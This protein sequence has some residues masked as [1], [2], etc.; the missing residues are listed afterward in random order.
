MIMRALPLLLVIM[1]ARQAISLNLNEG[2][3]VSQDA[4]CCQSCLSSSTLKICSDWSTIYAVKKVQWFLSD[5]GVYSEI[6]NVKDQTYPAKNN[7]YSS[8]CRQCPPGWYRTQD[9]LCF[10][11]QCSSSTSCPGGQYV[12]TSCTPTTNFG[13]SLCGT[14]GV[15]Q[16]TQT[17]CGGTS[18]IVCQSCPSGK[19]RDSY[20]VNTQTAC[21]DCAVCKTSLRQYRQGCTASSNEK[22]PVCPEGN[23]VKVGPPDSCQLCS[24]GTYARASDNTCVT[25]KTCARTEKQ[26]SACLSTGDRTCAACGDNRYTLAVNADTC[27]GCIQSYYLTGAGSCALCADSSCGNG[28]YRTCSFTEAGGG[29]R[30]CGA[31][32][33]QTENPKCDA[34]K[35]VSTRCNGMG[36]DAVTCSPCGPGLE[37]PI[38]TALVG[39]IQACVAC[40]LGFFKDATGV[41]NC[42]ACTNKPANNTQYVSWGTT[43]PSAN[44]C[45]W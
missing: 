18:N 27:A 36:T 19:Y 7:G 6:P 43:S 10:C 26:T 40:G 42:G 20:I 44:A 22:C 31:C 28:N 29:T 25:C 33:G 2:F 34:G 14:C 5:N 11:R 37:R 3:P 8:Q 15:G 41:A 30:T 35:G 9:N 24:D 45:P 13:C 32:E 23:I 4:P 16:E 21:A 17:A 12:S 38:T 1:A 39:N